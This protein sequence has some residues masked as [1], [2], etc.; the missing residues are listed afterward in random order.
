MHRFSEMAKIDSSS[1]MEI[2][3]LLDD[4][5]FEQL[6]ESIEPEKIPD[7]VSKVKCLHCPKLCASERGLKRHTRNQHPE[8]LSEAE[9]LSLSNKRKS[10]EE[11]L[12]P[13]KF[14]NLVH[15]CMEKLSEDLCYP[16]DVRNVFKKKLTVDVILVCYDHVKNVI[17]N[18]R[19]D[20]EKFFP[21]FY[22]K[23]NDGNVI[24]SL[25]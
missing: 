12:H 24:A 1:D 8:T 17:L 6:L 15:E 13:L 19:G 25:W 14:K 20:S 9:Q 4:R 11:L 21:N 10:A 16:E 7:P 2:D 23:F 22:S 5:E 3:Y 18:C